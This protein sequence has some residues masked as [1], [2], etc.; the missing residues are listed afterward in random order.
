MVI[1][2]PGR[3]FCEEAATL[4]TNVFGRRKRGERFDYWIGD[5]LYG[6]MNCLLYDH[7]SLTCRP[8]ILNK[9][10]SLGVADGSS[11]DEEEAKYAPIVRTEHASTIFGPTCDSFDMVLDDIVLPELT[12]DDWLVFPNMGAYTH[13][14]AS[15]FNGFSPNAPKTFYVY[16][17]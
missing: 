12:R 4:V 9:E 13:V 7:A 15:S 11:S 5:G 1:A 8:L 10:K 16:C 17:K 2:E 6:S 14:A 3:F